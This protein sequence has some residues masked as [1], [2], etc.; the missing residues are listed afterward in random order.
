MKRIFYIIL[1]VYL[2]LSMVS[3]QVVGSGGGGPP[4][5]GVNNEDPRIPPQHPILHG[6]PLEEGVKKF[7]ACTESV[8]TILKILT[9]QTAKETSD[10]Q[11]AVK[12]VD[13]Y[14]LALALKFPNLT[15]KIKD[16][17]FVEQCNQLSSAS[18]SELVIL[19]PESMLL[20]SFRSYS[21]LNCKKERL[22]NNYFD[23][24]KVDDYIKMLQAVVH[25][26]DEL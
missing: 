4:G 10:P 3:A 25:F 2:S 9:N 11:T 23:Q 14:F 22:L 15:N 6:N 12:K 26:E 5:S 13:E 21:E 19:T 16:A 24:S 17:N 1:G 7:A 18:V 8:D 20:K